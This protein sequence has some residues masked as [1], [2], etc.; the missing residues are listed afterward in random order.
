MCRK[1]FEIVLIYMLTE[2]CITTFVFWNEVQSVADLGGAWG[3][4]LPPPQIEKGGGQ[5][6]KWPPQRGA[7]CLKIAVEF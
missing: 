5:T 7:I 1:H 2:C 6:V 3:H 4:G